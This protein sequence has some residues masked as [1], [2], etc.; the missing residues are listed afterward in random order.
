VLEASSVAPVT[1]YVLGI[2]LDPATSSLVSRVLASSGDRVKI[3]MSLKE[4]VAQLERARPDVVLVDIGMEQ[5]GGLAVLHHVHVT[6]PEVAVVTLAQREQ[7]ELALQASGLGST[8]L[9]L[10]PLSGDELHTTLNAVRERLAER[11]SRR[12]RAEELE[13]LGLKSALTGSAAAMEA[14]R[15]R[16]EASQAWLEAILDTGSIDAGVLYVPVAEGERQLVRLATVGE[17]PALPSFSEQF[18]V[19]KLARELGLEALALQ[20]ADRFEGLLLVAPREGTPGAAFFTSGDAQAFA[21][22]GAASLATLSA[23]EQSRSAA[24]KD[25]RSS[26]YTFAYFVDVAG[27]EIE[28]ATRHRRRFALA[29]LAL[30]GIESEQEVVDAVEQILAVVRDTDV[31]A[32]VDEAEL[33]L[34]LPETGGIGAHSCRRRVMRQLEASAILGPNGRTALVGV[35]SFPHDGAD[36]S[37]LLRVAR[38]RAEA[39][40][41]SS[42]R[43]LNLEGASLPMLTDLLLSAVSITAPEASPDGV[44]L[45]ELPTMDAIGLAVSVVEQAARGGASRI[46]CGLG[47]GVSLGAAAR[48][49]VGR[50]SEDDRVDAID[51]KQLPG[52]GQLEL[53]CLLAE[54]GSYTLLGKVERGIVRAIHSADPLLVDQVVRCLHATTGRRLFD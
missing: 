7:L 34:L 52:C 30:E 46:V 33:Y 13:R 51:M 1:L 29:T 10:L 8:A 40:R 35:A 18:D 9:A 20:F 27:R 31:V 19:E 3:A 32:R 41:H 17:A 15:N 12:H 37:Q 5:G 16:T 25:P 45:I 2:G 24:L 6:A 42:V 26:A 22:F 39:S 43:T 14:S 23:V 36:L 47:E 28:K 44:Y 49:A 50:D 4:A 21:V 38:H 11:R 48:A 54:H 53:L